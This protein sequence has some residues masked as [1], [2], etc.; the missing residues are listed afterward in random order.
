MFTP[1]NPLPHTLLLDS[2]ARVPGSPLDESANVGR[3]GR[4]MD[5]KHCWLSWPP[6]ALDR[7]DNNAD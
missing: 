1:P 6:V 2:H 4:Q 5:R 3:Q 7:A